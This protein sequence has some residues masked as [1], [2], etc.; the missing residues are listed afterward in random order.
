MRSSTSSMLYKHIYIYKHTHTLGVCVF[1]THTLGVC[2]KTR[3][4]VQTYE[5]VSV[6]SVQK[7]IQNKPLV[8]LR[9]NKTRVPI[10]PKINCLYVTILYK[11]YTTCF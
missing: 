9:H 7:Q 6:L 4:G 3:V 5:C 2:F 8:P 10:R 11:R 1:K